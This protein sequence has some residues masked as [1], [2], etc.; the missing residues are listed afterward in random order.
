MHRMPIAK[1]R[2]ISNNIDCYTVDNSY[3]DFDRNSFTCV[4]CN[5][6]IEFSRQPKNS[7]LGPFFENRKNISH[8]DSCK[9]TSIVNNYLQR[10]GIEEKDIHESIANILCMIIPYTK[11]LNDVK[12]NY[13]EREML[14]NLL[15]SKVTKRF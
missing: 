15:S 1:Y 8:L 7:T 14:I 5:V 10:R 12:R 13:T 2:N 4:S 11:R 9:I 3:S 6:K